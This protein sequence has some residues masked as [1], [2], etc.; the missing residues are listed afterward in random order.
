VGKT[1][2]SAPFRSSRRVRLALVTALGLAV[3]AFAVPAHAGTSSVT[4]LDPTATLNDE[5]LSATDTGSGLDSV[6]VTTP[7]GSPS[8]PSGPPGGGSAGGAAAAIVTPEM[9]PTDELEMPANKAVALEADTGIAASDPTQGDAQSPPV[10]DVSDTTPA[11]ISPTPVESEVARS[12]VND[13]SVSEPVRSPVNEQYHPSSRQYQPRR[14]VDDLPRRASRGAAHSVGRWALHNQGSRMLKHESKFVQIISRICADIDPGNPLASAE[15][16]TANT[17]GNG[18]QIGGCIVDLT[19]NDPSVEGVATPS[20]CVDGSQYQPASGQYQVPPCDQGL[21]E[22]PAPNAPAAAECISSDVLSSIDQVLPTGIVVGIA[23]PVTCASSPAAPPPSGTGAS[24][25]GG[26]VGGPETATSIPAFPASPI[27]PP[28]VEPTTSQ[29]QPAEKAKAKTHRAVRSVAQ[30]GADDVLAAAAVHPSLANNQ[31]S[32]VAASG[33]GPAQKKRH[34]PARVPVTRGSRTRVE[35]LEAQRVGT[36][37]GHPS[38]FSGSAWLAAAVLLLLFGLASF[39]SAIAGTPKPA[40][41]R[42]VGVLVS[43]KGL[44]K[45]PLGGRASRQRG[46]RYRD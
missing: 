41:L 5:A 12:V 37:S 10:A 42:H 14:V 1:P 31:T 16:A 45:H 26:P 15:N 20:P 28:R 6:D 35:A 17:G 23:S 30:T 18:S 4:S 29:A 39:A 44:S 2:K 7:L 25:S 38:S 19:G 27:S 36:A 34:V 8:T 33:V 43:S 13:S 9:A 32:P 40:V 24:S 46:I 21:G 22:Q 11:A 3:V